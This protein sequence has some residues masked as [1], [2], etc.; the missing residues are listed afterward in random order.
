M[1]LMIAIPCLDMMRTEFVMS[2]TKI[3][4]K[5]TARG[6]DFEVRFAQS[7]LTYQGRENLAREALEGGFDF[8][9]WFDSDMDIP[10][11]AYDRL[12]SVMREKG[13]AL[14]TGIY[15]CRRRMY[16]YL[17][18]RLISSFQAQYYGENL[19]DEPFEIE[20][21]GFGCVLVDVKALKAV[22]GKY[23][24]AFT[25][26]NGLGEDLAFCLRLKELGYKMYAEPSVKCG[27]IG[28]IRIGCEDVSKLLGR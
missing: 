21:C 2:L 24:T 12:M 17:V 15:R 23:T 1:R 10:D 27:H 4:K 13:C 14:V 22:F 20:G 9:L 7:T 8:M 3:V 28:S 11:F 26:L 5:L 18:Y 16:Q 6:I 25:P 19:P